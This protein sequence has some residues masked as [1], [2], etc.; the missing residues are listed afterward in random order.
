[1]DLSKYT[2]VKDLEILKINI[3]IKI[4]ELNF[5]QYKKQLDIDGYFITFTSDEAAYFDHLSNVNYLELYTYAEIISDDGDEDV[6]E[7][8]GDFSY[9]TLHQKV[10]ELK[11]PAD[12]EFRFDEYLFNDK[13][14]LKYQLN[15]LE[16]TSEGLSGEYCDDGISHDLAKIQ[17]KLYFNI[18]KVPPNGLK[19][20]AIN[21]D[22]DVLNLEVKDDKIYHNSKMYF[23][24]SVWDELELCIPW[25]SDILDEFNMNIITLNGTFG[26]IQLDLHEDEPHSNHF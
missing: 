9:D 8:Y 26:L 1:M 19:F 23:N 25:Y 24:L 16:W 6:W 18:L 7:L 11:L 10:L 4:K 15:E 3:D 13:G 12:K 22:G 20:Q 17:C 5:D 2:T 14:D 21:I